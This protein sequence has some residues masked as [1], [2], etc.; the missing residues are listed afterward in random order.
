M[1]GTVE[2]FIEKLNEW[3]NRWETTP[4]EYSL[5]QVGYL[6]KVFTRYLLIYIKYMTNIL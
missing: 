1:Y 4:E 6:L 3:L 5:T 2:D